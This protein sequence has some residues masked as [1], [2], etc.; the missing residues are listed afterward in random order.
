MDD[1]VERIGHCMV[2]ACSIGAG[3]WILLASLMGW[4]S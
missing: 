3:V 1:D 4:L 2:L